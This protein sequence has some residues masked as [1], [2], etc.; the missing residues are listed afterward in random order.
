MFLALSLTSN[1]IQKNLKYKCG[2]IFSTHCVFFFFPPWI[3]LFSLKLQ[4]IA[5]VSLKGLSHKNFRSEVALVHTEPGH[6]LK[7]AVGVECQQN[8][9]EMIPVT[10]LKFWICVFRKNICEWQFPVCFNQNDYLSA[11]RQFLLLDKTWSTKPNYIDSINTG[12]FH[13]WNLIS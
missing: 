4:G 9:E 5:N 8:T 11:Q 10:E 2:Q 13:A 3:H 12:L 6:K 1:K 7:Q